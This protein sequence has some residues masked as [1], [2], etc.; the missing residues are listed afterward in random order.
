M[1]EGVSSLHALDFVDH[2]VDHF[3][4]LLG[5]LPGREGV[6]Y[7]IDGL[8]FWVLEAVGALD[9][10]ALAVAFH[11]IHLVGFVDVLVNADDVAVSVVDLLF[12]LEEAVA[13]EDLDLRGKF[14]WR[15]DVVQLLRTVRVDHEILLAPPIVVDVYY[16]LLFWI[17][18]VRHPR[19]AFLVSVVVEGGLLGA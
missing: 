17:L 18:A 12:L 9:N 3:L 8:F 4:L 13:V 10:S 2:G 6:E 5:R 7:G 14:L 11:L 16:A 1:G 19:K 15:V